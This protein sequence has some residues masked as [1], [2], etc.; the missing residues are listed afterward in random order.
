[1]AAVSARSSR[2]GAPSTPRPARPI[3]SAGRGERG[4]GIRWWRFASIHRRRRQRKPQLTKQ[5]H[6]NSCANYLDIYRNPN[7]HT[8]TKRSN[9]SKDAGLTSCI[10]HLCIYL[11]FRTPAATSNSSPCGRVKIPP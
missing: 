9:T 10:L 4:T 8:T 3:R 7:R 6:D 1:M 2:A 11:S 5:P